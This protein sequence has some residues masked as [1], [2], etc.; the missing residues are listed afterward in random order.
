MNRLACFISIFLTSTIALASPENGK[1]CIDEIGKKDAQTL[2]KW[3]IETSPATHPPCNYE[4]SCKMIAD[5][6]KRGCNF[7]AD[8]A[9]AS[10]FYCFLA[11]DSK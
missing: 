9:N 10:P 6:I 11:K 8:P 7:A 4:N 1:R 2:V 5:E 3:C